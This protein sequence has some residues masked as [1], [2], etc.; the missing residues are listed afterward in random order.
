MPLLRRPFLLALDLITVIE[1]FGA[2]LRFRP[3]GR[4]RAALGHIQLLL[5]QRAPRLGVLDRDTVVGEVDDLAGQ[6]AAAS[7][8][9][10]S[11]AGWRNALSRPLITAAGAVAVGR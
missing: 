8:V 11:S 9:N 7:A 6:R 3:R 1:R 5:D 10:A 2:P 4:I